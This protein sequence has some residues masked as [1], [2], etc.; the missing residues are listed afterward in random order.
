MARR[1]DVSQQACRGRLINESRMMTG[2]IPQAARQSH[3]STTLQYYLTER[4][5][6][7]DEAQHAKSSLSP[8]T[9]LQ[10]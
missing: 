10:N 6:P 9:E 4:H 7:I 8:N 5:R 3:S 1:L 2:I